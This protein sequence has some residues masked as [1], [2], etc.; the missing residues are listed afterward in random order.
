ML[1]RIASALALIA[2]AC[3][4]SA[5]EEQPQASVPMFCS[6]IGPPIEGPST[7]IGDPILPVNRV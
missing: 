6:P 1:V 7:D 2:I 4:A 3:A 5:D